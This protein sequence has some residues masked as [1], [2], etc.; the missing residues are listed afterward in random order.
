MFTPNTLSFFVLVVST[1]NAFDL[2]R[3]VRRFLQEDSAAPFDLSAS[4][5][6]SGN[7]ANSNLGGT[8]VEDDESG[9]GS[10]AIIATVVVLLLLCCCFVFCCIGGFCYNNNKNSN[11]KESVEMHK[12]LAIQHGGPVQYSDNRT[13]GGSNMTYD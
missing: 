7:D 2:A 9:G 10:A 11:Q 1:A 8:Q 4:L 6:G 5:G 3:E 13:V 12:S